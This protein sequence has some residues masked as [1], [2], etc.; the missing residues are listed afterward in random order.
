MRGCRGCRSGADHPLRHVPA[1]PSGSPR[2]AR[3]STPRT[4]RSTASPAAQQFSSLAVQQSLRQT[5]TRRV[6]ATNPAVQTKKQKIQKMPSVSAPLRLTSKT[7]P[8][9]QRDHEK[10]TKKHIYPHTILTQTNSPQQNKN[11]AKKK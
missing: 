4:R 6:M 8:T 3:L 7:G 2:S 9:G 10:N 11:K 5:A 1:G